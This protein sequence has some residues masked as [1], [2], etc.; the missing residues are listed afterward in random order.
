MMTI[1]SQSGSSLKFRTTKHDTSSPSASTR[2][3]R[4]RMRSDIASPMPGFKDPAVWNDHLVSNAA[5]WATQI[6]NLISAPDKLLLLARAVRPSS[7]RRAPVCRHAPLPEK[8]RSQTRVLPPDSAPESSQG[9]RRCVAACLRALLLS[10]RMMPISQHFG[11]HLHT[12]F[13]LH[14]SPPSTL[15]RAIPTGIIAHS[16]SH[17]IFALSRRRRHSSRSQSS[18]LLQPCSRHFTSLG[19]LASKGS[20]ASGG[21]ARTTQSQLWAATLQNQLSLASE[22]WSHASSSYELTTALPH[23]KTNVMLRHTSTSLHTRRTR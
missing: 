20:E 12:V 9:H 10:N 13:G 22:A 19:A 8:H 3:S 18:M 4:L 14:R 6:V 23:R 5:T 11:S 21:S 16:R 17:H 2:S 7:G 15:I 1:I